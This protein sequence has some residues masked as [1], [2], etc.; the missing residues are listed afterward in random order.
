MIE[1]IEI[2]HRNQKVYALEFGWESAEKAECKVKSNGANV[3]WECDSL[4]GFWFSKIMKDG[5]LMCL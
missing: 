2:P 1:I 3:K 4:F 5:A